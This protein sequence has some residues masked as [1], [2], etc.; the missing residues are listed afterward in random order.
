MD[1]PV[2]QKIPGFQAIASSIPES[3]CAGKS[4]NDTIVNKTSENKSLDVQSRIRTCCPHELNK[5]IQFKIS[6][7][8]PNMNRNS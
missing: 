2:G 1:Y 3:C 8:I 5:G 4:P 7:T 6:G